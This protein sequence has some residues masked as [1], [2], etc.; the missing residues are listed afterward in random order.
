MEG[1]RPTDEL[2][3]RMLSAV[4]GT[5]GGDEHVARLVGAARAEAEAEVKE[6]LKAAV[7]ATLLQRAV[8]W[9][10]SGSSLSEVPIPD[11]HAVAPAAPESLSP[12]TAPFAA[13][14]TLYRPWMG[15]RALTPRR[16]ATGDGHY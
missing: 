1:D 10:E 2:I 5:F 14:A 3:Q 11:A 4:V 12:D 8:A 16:P 7:K 6:L 9:L 15:P 13:A